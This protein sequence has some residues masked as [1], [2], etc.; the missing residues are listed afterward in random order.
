MD[1]KGIAIDINEWTRYQQ[2]VHIPQKNNRYDCGVFVLMCARAIAYNQ[3]FSSYHQRDAPRYRSMIGRHILQGSLL[4]FIDQSVPYIF[5]LSPEHQTAQPH[6]EATL[7]LNV[8]RSLRRKT[9]ISSQRPLMFTHVQPQ[10]PYSTKSAAAAAAAA[11][12]E[13]E[14]DSEDSE[15]IDDNTPKKEGTKYNPH[16]IYAQVNMMSKFSTTSAVAIV[17][18]I[19]SVDYEEDADD[20]PTE[21]MIIG[22]AMFA[23][24]NGTKTLSVTKTKHS[25]TEE[26]LAYSNSDTE[27]SS[28]TCESET[29]FGVDAV[30]T[31][32]RNR[33]GKSN[34]ALT[35]KN[36]ALRNSYWIKNEQKR[37]S[38]NNY[39]TALLDLNDSDLTSMPTG[40]D[41]QVR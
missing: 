15:E 12:V 29:K 28:E 3:P 7:S 13:E 26:N 5:Q 34:E 10:S 40:T 30:A 32:T 18:E 25:E 16:N 21:G 1:K 31:S 23:Q 19:D 20:K 8:G 41:H 24:E 4:D 36:K 14:E 38:N 9:N 39:K 37:K 2:E 35:R 11:A 22:S 33:R 17:Q 6:Q 27:G